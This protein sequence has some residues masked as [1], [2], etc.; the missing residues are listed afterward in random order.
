MAGRKKQWVGGHPKARKKGKCPRCGRKHD[1]SAHWSHKAN[2]GD[3]SYKHSPTR[4]IKRSAESSSYKA[5]KAAR[6]A[7]SARGRGA[8]YAA[9]SRAAAQVKP[10]KR[11]AKQEAQLQ[12][13]L[14]AG[15]AAR[16]KK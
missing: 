1:R 9:R 10:K 8:A 13:F 6:K 12:K 5:R 11:T 16:K 3:K 4:K 2:T 15:R 7:S 14:A